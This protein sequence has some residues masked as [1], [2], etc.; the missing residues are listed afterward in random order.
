MAVPTTSIILMRNFFRFSVIA[1]TTLYC[2]SSATAQTN[3]IGPNRNRVTSL[4]ALTASNDSVAFPFTMPENGRI[5]SVRFNMGRTAPFL[6]GHVYVSILRGTA[7]NFVTHRSGSMVTVAQTPAGQQTIGRA[8]E[9]DFSNQTLD[10]GLYWLR[11]TVGI[12]TSSGGGNW[13]VPTARLSGA[14][15]Y[16]CYYHVHGQQGWRLQREAPKFTVIY[17]NGSFTASGQ[18]CQGATRAPVLQAPQPRDG[19]Q[20]IQL[21]GSGGPSSTAIALLIGNRVF[22]GGVDLSPLG[23]NGCRLYVDSFVALSGV[24]YPSGLWDRRLTYDSPATFYTQFAILAPGE[25]AFGVLTT[26]YGR[27]FTGTG[28]F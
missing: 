23:A 21:R 4:A 5:E 8:F 14:Q 2:V 12:P 19:S 15:L 3:S 28:V 13:Y 24:T 18:S 25:N 16:N 6:N 26:N 1:F 27:T 17:N 9:S 20:T 22:P 7:P 10:A 11:L